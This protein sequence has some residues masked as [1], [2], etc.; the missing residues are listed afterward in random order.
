MKKSGLTLYMEK[1]PQTKA[2]AAIRAVEARRRAAKPRAKLV[3]VV[4]VKSAS[5]R[6][7]RTASIRRRPS[8]G[9]SRRMSTRG[10]GKVPALPSTLATAITLPALADN[11]RLVVSPGEVSNSA[12]ASP[13]ATSNVT[14]GAVLGTYDSYYLGAGTYWVA[15]FRDPLRATVRFEANP[16]QTLY[17]YL[18]Y[19]PV[20]SGAPVSTEVV[21]HGQN[22]Y[23]LQPVWLAAQTTYRPHGDYL[24]CGNDLQDNYYIFL[25]KGTTVVG[26]QTT[27]TCTVTVTLTGTLGV[28]T[29]LI[30]E[31]WQSGTSVFID[32]V[33]VS[34]GECTFVPLVPG[35]YCFSIDTVNGT[36]V[37]TAALLVSSTGDCLAHRAVPFFDTLLP[38]V[39]KYRINAAALQLTDVAAKLNMGGRI[40][41]C[42][43]DGAVDFLSRISAE[44]ITT[45]GSIENFDF[46]ERNASQGSYAYLKPKDT[47]DLNFRSAITSKSGQIQDCCWPINDPSAYTVARIECATQ[48]VDTAA[49]TPGLDFII[50]EYYSLEFLT[51]NMNF[52]RHLAPCNYPDFVQAMMLLRTLPAFFENPSHFAM[53]LKGVKRAY[54]IIR[55]HGPPITQLLSRLSPNFRVPGRLLSAGL[56]TLPEW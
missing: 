37:N 33:T 3:P 30:V 4:A 35:Y 21:T 52:E 6:P 19:F 10:I 16:E 41:N 17:T 26:G 31:Q 44:A 29:S 51:A 42:W 22:V 7:K 39:N 40:Y 1:H 12:V 43:C 53:L 47:S 50:R 14:S 27:N 56:A 15:Q 9:L 45:N 55:L 46:A 2:A 20:T 32:K 8:A 38:V 36:N 24:Y 54:N 25:D 5:S 34:D 18:A 23:K 48:G 28:G 13:H 11:L 49:I